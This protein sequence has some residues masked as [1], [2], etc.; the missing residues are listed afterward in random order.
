MLLT[1]IHHSP[2]VRR[3]L[4]GAGIPVIEVW[5]LTDK[6]IDMCVGFSH[7]DAGRAVADFVYDAGYRVAAT[8]TAAD[9]RARRRATAFVERFAARGG[10]M[11]DGF[12]LPGPASLAE[13]RRGLCELWDN[14]G[15]AGGVVFCS[16]NLLAHGAVIEAQK[17]ELHIPETVAI[18]GFGDQDFAAHT[19]PALTTVS[20]DRTA[21][22]GAAAKA[23]LVNING[24][25]R[26]PRVENIGFSIYRRASA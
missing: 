10:K 5:D 19:E 15:F 23:L 8:I 18:I 2:R 6:P 20:V 16:S 3:I 24:D 14:Q 25:E 17:R 4:L 13:G 9:E 22:C 26:M 11:S 1:E 7:A 21:L 12:N